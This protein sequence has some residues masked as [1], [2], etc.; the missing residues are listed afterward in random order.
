MKRFY[1]QAEAAP[2]EHGFGVQLDGRALKTPAKQTLMCPS[3]ELAQLVAEEWQAQGDE[4]VPD[5]MP[6][7]RLVATALD[8]VSAAIDETAAA[9]AAYG[10]SDLLCYRAEHPDKLVERQAAQ[11]E[12]WLDWARRRY[13]MSF[14]VTAGILPVSQPD[15]T[16]LRFQEI[17][18]DE[19]FRVTG[20]AFGAPLLGSAVLTLA[21]AEGDIDAQMAYEVSQLDDIFQIE[22][23]G[24][25]H[26]AETK[27][28]RRQQEIDA[29]GRYFSALAAR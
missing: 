24:A 16:E 27:L 29:L 2:L 11:W 26:E 7:M 17:A 6:I 21:L 18:G 4:I 25:D 3:A 15:G 23:W 10:L 8:R 5:A 13:D 9:F 28:A 1:E 14:N 19:P 22:Q 20:L 12:P